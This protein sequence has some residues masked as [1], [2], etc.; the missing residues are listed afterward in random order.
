MKRVLL[1]FVS[2]LLFVSGWGIVLADTL[3]PHKQASRALQQQ[4]AGQPVMAH[5]QESPCHK[6][7]DEPE[8]D[9]T[10]AVLDHHTEICTHCFRSP[11]TQA[12]LFARA[13]ETAKRD[14]CDVIAQP[15]VGFLSQPHASFAPPVQARQ[16]APPGTRARRHL[17]LNLFLI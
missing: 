10:G 13:P 8:A 12:R 6:A 17:L 4:Q 7:K 9:K 16:H 11:E 5:G 2:S 14:A 15:P 3:C 1:I